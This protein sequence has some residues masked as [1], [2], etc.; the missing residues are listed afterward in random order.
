MSPHIYIKKH[1]DTHV[2]ALFAVFK[3]FPKM[4]VNFLKMNSDAIFQ[5]VFS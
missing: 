3:Y 4:E 2:S 1:S 5:C